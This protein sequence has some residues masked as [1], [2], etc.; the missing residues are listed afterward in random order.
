LSLYAFTGK[1]IAAQRDP[2]AHRIGADTSE[3]PLE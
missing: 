3:L 2:L 1:R